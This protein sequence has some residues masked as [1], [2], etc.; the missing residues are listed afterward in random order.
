LKGGIEW[1]R[2]KAG[3]SGRGGKGQDTGMLRVLREGEPVPLEEGRVLC[4]TIFAMRLAGYDE[5]DSCFK[6]CRDD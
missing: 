3:S 2:L 6:L 5:P 4:C 1:E